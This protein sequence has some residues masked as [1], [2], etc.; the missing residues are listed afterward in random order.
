MFEGRKVVNILIDVYGYVLYCNNKLID[1]LEIK[2]LY[3]DEIILIGRYIFFE[4]L[5]DI[6]KR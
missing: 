5:I 6:N 1:N 2:M 4:R 3:L